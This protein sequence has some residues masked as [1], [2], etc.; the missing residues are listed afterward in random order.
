MVTA[1]HT[2]TVSVHPYTG[3]VCTPAHTC[4][5]NHMC[6]HTGRHSNTQTDHKHTPT[7]SHLSSTVHTRALVCTHMCTCPVLDG[8]TNTCVPS[9]AC[10]HTRACVRPPQPSSP[11]PTPWQHTP[12]KDIQLYVPIAIPAM[13]GPEPMAT[14]EAMWDLEARNKLHCHGNEAPWTDFSQDTARLMADVRAAPSHCELAGPWPGWVPRHGVPAHGYLS[15]ARPAR[16]YLEEVL[17]VEGG[18]AHQP[19]QRAGNTQG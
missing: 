16:W 10:E 9:P 5:G 1:G 6:P 17:A 3:T 7:H 13:P 2:P 19:G 15:R 4:R 18:L 14:G 8:V 12:C 11:A